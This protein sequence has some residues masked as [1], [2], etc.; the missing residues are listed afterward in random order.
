MGQIT[1]NKQLPA[2]PVSQ[3]PAPPAFLESGYSEDHW[4]VMTQQFFPEAKK[5]ESIMLVA[6]YCKARK[7]DLMSKP[8]H[9][10]P[11]YK[12]GSYVD[13][14]LP[15]V[16]L[17][18]ITAHRT[19]SFAGCDAPEYG[20]Q[21]RFVFRGTGK[22]NK[23]KEFVVN[24]PEYCRV[25]V[26]RLVNGTRYA[27]TG[28]AWYEE[29]A[30]LVKGTE[31]DNCGFP[32]DNWRN[33]SRMMLAKCA[34][35]AALRLA[36]PE[37]C[38]GEM[39]AEE[40]EGQSVYTD[41][42]EEPR[43]DTKDLKNDPATQALARAGSGSRKASAKPPSS[44]ESVKQEEVVDATVVQPTAQSQESPGN[45]G[46]GLPPQEAAAAT[47]EDP[48]RIINNSE[49]AEICVAAQPKGW[50]SIDVQRLSCKQFKLPP[51]DH[52]MITLR[53]AAVL[54]KVVTKYGTDILKDKEAQA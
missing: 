38:G 41:D 32:N 9:I 43:A 26:Y 23:S 53:Q 45:A 12:N 36:F 8:F 40:M 16:N 7:L 17:Y 24:T 21:K 30:A 2:L 25:T 34:K 11:F 22:N 18:E 37:E 46:D 15:G 33:K 10:V 42:Q 28:E 27:F 6:S 39:T 47:T 51:G 5:A 19:G 44:G 13:Q 35:A 31:S 29:Y 3:Q 48:D 52:A 1:A 50:M 20:P 4:K 14:V 49:W 54:K